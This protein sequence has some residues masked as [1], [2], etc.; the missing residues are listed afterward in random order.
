MNKTMRL[1]GF[2]VVMLTCSYL[3]CQELDSE[4]ARSYIE[5]C[6]AVP[7]NRIEQIHGGLTNKSF[8]V[9]MSGGKCVARF[10][11]KNPHILGINRFCEAACQ[12]RAS[13]LGIAPK[14][15]F[16]DPEQGTLMSA[17]IEGTTL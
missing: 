3:Y 13:E 6:L 11:K 14:I 17:F 7:V 10:G 1:F 9:T 2:F 15:L 5:E 12:Q 16:S 8:A 4:S